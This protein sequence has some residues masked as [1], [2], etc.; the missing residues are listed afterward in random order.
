MSEP[1][2]ILLSVLEKKWPEGIPLREFDD[3]IRVMMGLADLLA[4]SRPMKKQRAA[5]AAHVVAE[6][7][8]SGEWNATVQPPPR[9]P[10]LQ[11]KAALMEI[12]S[13]GEGHTSTALALALG[14][15]PVTIATH[16]R[17]L[18]ATSTRNGA[19]GLNVWRLTT[20]AKPGPKGPRVT[21]KTNRRTKRHGSRWTSPALDIARKHIATLPR[22]TLLNAG[23]LSR[24]WDVGNRVIATALLE[25]GASRSG[26][27][28]H[29]RWT[30]P[31][32][33]TVAAPPNP[34]ESG[35]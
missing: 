10:N 29:M 4:P 13:D 3:V 30:L 28:P 35:K 15:N 1:T 31:E 11:T 32:V 7:G 9:I 23:E 19:N 25:A 26:T 17:S 5:P 8:V 34:E 33:R 18:G 24:R 21:P 2:D 12:L 20:R 14:R 6:R 16:A 22:G 27:G